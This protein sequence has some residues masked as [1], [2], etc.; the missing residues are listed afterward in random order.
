MDA[1]S[2]LEIV[3]AEGA[4][5]LSAARTL[6]QEY[7]DSFGFTPCFQGFG[8][9]LA[10][11]PGGYAPPRGRLGLA[12]VGGE[13]AGCVALRPVDAGRCEAKRLFVRPKFRG[14]GTGKALLDWAIAEARAAGYAEMLGD[15]MPVMERALAMYDR[16]GFER[17][18][19]YLEQPTAGAICIRLKL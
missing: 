16:A 9:E 18:G 11:L 8:E 19:P 13:P 10:N 14:H 4:E 15:T 7:W 2:E 1:R 17:T 3:A 12:L 6:F 5:R